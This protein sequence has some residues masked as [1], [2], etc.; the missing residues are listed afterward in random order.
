MS[1]LKPNDR[2]IVG[3]IVAFVYSILVFCNFSIAQSEKKIDSLQLVLQKTKGF[4]QIEILSK[5]SQ[6]YLNVSEKQAFVYAYKALELASKSNNQNYLSQAYFELGTIH[7]KITS[8]DSSLYYYNKSLRTSMSNEKTSLILDNIGVLYKDKSSYDSAL[9]FHNQSLKLKETL[10]DRMGVAVSYTNI[11]NVYFQ[12]KKFDDALDYYNQALAIRKEKQDKSLVA[13]SLNNVGDAYKNMLQYDK[14]L[15]CFNEALAIQKEIGNKAIIANTLHYIGNFYFQLKIYDKAQEY[16]MKALEIRTELGNKNDIA[17][18]LFNIATVHRDIGNYREALKYY[19]KA[20]TLRRETGAK[21][22]EAH[23]LTALGGLYKNKKLYKLAIYNYELALEM[24]SKMG[25]KQHIA[26]SYERLGIAYK[27]TCLYAKAQEYYTLAY[28]YFLQ[29][30]NM[31][32]V[33]RIY[34]YLGNLYKEKNDEPL[35]LQFYSRSFHLYDSLRNNVGMA[36]VSNNIAKLYEKIGNQAN[37]ISNY[38]TALHLAQQ[39]KEYDLKQE[40]AFALYTIYK[41]NKQFAQALDYYEIY[42]ATK[43]TIAHNKNVQ[44][45]AEIEF[46]TNIKLLEQINENQD[47]KLREEQA[48]RTQFTLYLIIAIIILII[49]LLFSFLLYRQFTQKEKAYNLLSEKSNELEQAYSNLEQL[50]AILKERNEKITDSL[51]YAKR[52]QKAILPQESIIEKAFARN[53]I[54]YLPKEIVSGDFYWFTTQREY[55]FFAVVDC[56]GH[57]IPGAFM[58]M[59]GNTL[60][61]QI[62]NEQHF[63]EPSEILQKLDKEIIKTLKQYDEHTKQEDGMEISLIRYNTKTKQLVFAGAGHKIIVAYNNSIEIIS[64]SIFSIGGMHSIKKDNNVTFEQIDM[65]IIPGTTIYL[66]TDGYIDQFGGECD[67]RFSTNRF[68]KLIADIQS[69]DLC[70]QY[71]HISKTFDDWKGA[72][73]Q[74][75]DVLVVGISL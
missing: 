28:S 41:S 37:A 40:V 74:L 15:A 70:E 34:N 51:S 54:Y 16:Y 26:S 57:G 4:Q 29:V 68:Q 69:Y 10:G 62:V 35:S 43:D 42:T 60:L 13:A 61:N 23:I 73:S 30:Q 58:S 67:E 7:Y 33:A 65:K 46:E 45:I 63:T 56:T 6:E 5:L 14:A 53:F 19:D 20:L 59:V 44:R 39:S 50:H 38:K 72:T 48:K 11:G 36:Q 25:N 49:I 17:A 47:L 31:I 9:I 21:E 32:G 71:I 52:I 22:A 75:D 18:T 8:F 27:D 55:E 24:Y 1:V 64:S 3:K 12:M 66:F 2:P